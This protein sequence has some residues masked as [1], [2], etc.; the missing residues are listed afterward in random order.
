MFVC[1]RRLVVWSRDWFGSTV[2]RGLGVVW[3]VVI[4]SV[5]AVVVT[6]VA[7]VVGVVGVVIRSDAVSVVWFGVVL[8]DVVSRLHV[9]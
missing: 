3:S 7:A 8:C 6:V 5:V 2:A 1:I 9:V 4:V